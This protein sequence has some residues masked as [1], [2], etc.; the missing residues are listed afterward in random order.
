[1][2]SNG[3]FSQKAGA[4]KIEELINETLP[5][6]TY[7]TLPPTI[8]FRLG[9]VCNLQCVMCQP[10]DS[11][12]W[13]VPSKKL[14]KVLES[15]IKFDWQ[16]K[17]N[18][19]INQFDWAKQQSF[20]EDFYKIAPNIRHITFGGGEPLLVKEQKLLVKKLVDDNLAKN[21]ELLYHTNCTIYDQELLDYWSNFKSVK[22]MLSIDG[23]DSVNSYIRRPAN[24]DEIE[25]NLKLYDKTPDNIIVSI[26]CTIQLANI[27]NC[28]DFAKWLL[29]QKFKKVGVST[30]GG[31]FFASLLHWPRYLSIQVLPAHIKETA[32]TELLNFVNQFD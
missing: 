8:D 13:V 2:I 9:N 7:N 17:S 3:I 20:W 12:K 10:S 15:P 11:S 26:N 16:Y 24:W 32:T 21:I 30:D 4:H 18:L 5:D 14:S 19:D 29:D 27:L 31:I 28:V 23:T 22:L 6:G 25:Q 1:M